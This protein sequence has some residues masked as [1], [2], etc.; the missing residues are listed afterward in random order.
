MRSITRSAVAVIAGWLAM[1]LLVAA[2][3]ITAAL[4]IPGGISAMRG[5][6]PARLAAYLAANLAVSLAAAMAGGGLAARLAAKA[7][8]AHAAVLAAAIGAM[9]VAYAGAPQPGQPG[10]YGAAIAVLGV[11]GALAGGLVVQRRAPAAG[12][13]PARAR[14]I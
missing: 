11:A 1:M 3:T 12:S 2:G 4:L 10:W 9:S 5:T 14:T 13:A 7:P 6:A 8:L